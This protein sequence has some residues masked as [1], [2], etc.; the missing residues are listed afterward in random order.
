MSVLFKNLSVSKTLVSIDLSNY[1]TD[2]KNKL[3]AQGVEAFKAFV[4]N[5]IYLQYVVLSNLMLDDDNTQIIITALE[6]CPNLL[7]LNLQ[8][9]VFTGKCLEELSKN[10][11]INLN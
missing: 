1:E 7:V 10:F 6:E 4:K 9:N 5:N 8:S 2:K 3:G 11:L